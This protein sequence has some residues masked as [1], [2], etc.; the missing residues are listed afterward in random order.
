M[1]DDL[2]GAASWGQEIRGLHRVELMLDRIAQRAVSQLEVSLATAS[3][4]PLHHREV[5]RRAR[6]RHSDLPVSPPSRLSVGREVTGLPMPARAWWPAEPWGGGSAV[7]VDL[8]GDPSRTTS[9]GRPFLQLQDDSDE[10]F[11][12]PHLLAA[13]RFAAY[14]SLSLLAVER[15]AHLTAALETRGLISQAQGILMERFAVGPEAAMGLLRRWSQQSQRPVRDLAL[16]VTQ[17][18]SPSPDADR[19]TGPPWTR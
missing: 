12:P 11:G 15:V 16:E 4:M 18:R 2:P 10:F 3:A 7:L 17:H 13:A 8:S 1:D 14:A 9:S 5:P 19:G 6:G